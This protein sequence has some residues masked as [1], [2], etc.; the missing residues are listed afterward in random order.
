MSNNRSTDRQQV[1]ETSVFVNADGSLDLGVDKM[2]EV[3]AIMAASGY[4]SCT[5]SVLPLRN[6]EVAGYVTLFTDPNAGELQSNGYRLNA[7][8]R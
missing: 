8:A 3:A 6:V 4:A 7:R 1:V 5:V 2:I